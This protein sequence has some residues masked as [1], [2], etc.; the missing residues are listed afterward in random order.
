MALEDPTFKD[1]TLFLK[2]E[3]L[4]LYAR[5]KPTISKLLSQENVSFKSMVWGTSLLA[6]HWGMNM[7]HSRH[8]KIQ[9]QPYLIP[10]MDFRNYVASGNVYAHIRSLIISRPLISKTS[11]LTSTTRFKMIIWL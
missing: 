4:E 2:Q 6:F 1:Y 11:V 10:L 3:R 7:A 8:I 5:L 9:G